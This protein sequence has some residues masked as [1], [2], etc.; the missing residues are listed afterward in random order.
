VAALTRVSSVA[1]AHNIAVG[2]PQQPRGEPV[3]YVFGLLSE[4]SGPWRP[5]AST[6]RGATWTD[7]GASNAKGLGN[8]PSVMA[9]SRQA[10]GVFVVGSF[11]R[12]AFWA[13]ASLSLL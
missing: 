10:F 8:W 3:V 11:G 7:L 9:A 1:V 13:N 12:G 2:A 6:D 5:F 4:S